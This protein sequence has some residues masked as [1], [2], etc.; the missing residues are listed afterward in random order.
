MTE[1]PGSAV[2][3]NPWAWLNI[4]GR[5]SQLEHDQEMRMAQIDDLKA[6]QA[7]LVDVVNK[8]VARVDALQTQT[9]AAPPP[10]DMQTVIDAMNSAAA[11]AEPVANPPA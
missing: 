4:F 11:T 7:R 2:P 6:A 1:K 3:S 8:L 9:A 10:A 5:L